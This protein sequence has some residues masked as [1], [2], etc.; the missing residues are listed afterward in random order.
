[1]RAFY[2]AVEPGGCGFDVDMADAAVQ[3]VVVEL[4][5]ATRFQPWETGKQS[6]LCLFGLAVESGD[7]NYASGSQVH[8]SSATT[9][10]VSVGAGTQIS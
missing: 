6:L 7:V 8:M 10:T 3:H 5:L 9:Q 1:V 4:G 2:F